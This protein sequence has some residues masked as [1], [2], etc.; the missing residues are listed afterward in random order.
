MKHK[1]FLLVLTL[2]AVGLTLPG[3][4]APAA[5]AKKTAPASVS[6]VEGADL[7]LLTLL[8][9]AAKRLDIKTVVVREDPVVAKRKFAGEVISLS[10]GLNTAVVQVNLTE[11]DAKR[12]RRGETALLLPFARDSKAPAVTALPIQQPSKLGLYG[13]PGTIYYEVSGVNHGLENRQLVF[14][15]LPF[16]GSEEK[17]KIVPYAAVLYDSKGN[18]WVYTSPKEFVFIRHAIIIETIAGDEVFLG[19]GP[20]AGTA[21]VTV[22]GAELFGT[23]FG[24]GK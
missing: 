2:M 4:E 1:V 19:S 8:P 17:R 18:T 10:S 15:E 16:S 20:P 14:V 5:E 11:N 7:K 24:V 13:P 12:V 23:E 6:N 22:G 9:E 3:N 21:V